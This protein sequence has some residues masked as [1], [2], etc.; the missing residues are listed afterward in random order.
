[1]TVWIIKRVV[2]YA[3]TQRGITSLTVITVTIAYETSMRHKQG[4]HL[5]DTEGLISG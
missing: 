5:T 3:Y 2:C 4:L 1:M